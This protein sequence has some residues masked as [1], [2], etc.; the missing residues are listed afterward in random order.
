[1]GGVDGIEAAWVVRAKQ[2]RADNGRER[3]A[4]RWQMGQMADKWVMPCSSGWGAMVGQ[5]GLL[6]GWL[7]PL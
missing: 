1:V 5:L 4:R 6:G 3:A 2:K 7:E